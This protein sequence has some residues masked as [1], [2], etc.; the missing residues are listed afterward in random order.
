MR[1]QRLPRSAILDSDHDGLPDVYELERPP[2]NPMSAADATLDFDG[3]DGV[4]V[5][6][7]TVLQFS[8]PLAADTL[9]ENA[10]FFAEAA[11]RKVLSRPELSPDRRK[12][13]LF[14]L[15]PLPGATRVRVTFDAAAI[16]DTEGRLVD[17]DGDGQ[18][19]GV[20]RIEFD[21]L[22]NHPTPGTAVIGRVFASEL[23]AGPDTGTNAV[24]RPLK[25]AT[26]TVDGME[27]ALRAVTDAQGDFKLTNA[28]AG[29]FLVHVDGRTAAGSQWPDG[30]YYP[31][32]G[33]AWE[34]VAGRQDNL[35]GGTGEIYLPLI[36]AGS[37]KPV[38]VVGPTYPD[39][40]T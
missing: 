9:L 19:G 21:T 39:F 26:I 30:D 7:E 14:Y 27:E 13:T 36:Q 29:W 17:A 15:E 22:S 16:K 2:L 11:G 18:E 31:F 3:D 6:R 28:P 34:T 35:V 8:R 12:A 32:V 37:L 40:P 24:N 25:G 10:R 1:V 23:V 5:T 4:A 38:S 33:K 20:A